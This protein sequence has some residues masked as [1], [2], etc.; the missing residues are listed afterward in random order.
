MKKKLE[1][2]Q[3]LI[4]KQFEYLENLQKKENDLIQKQVQIYE[5]KKNLEEKNKKEKREKMLQEINNYREQAIQKKQQEKLQNKLNDINFI[6][7]YKK[8]MNRLEQLE[9]EK[10]E[11]KKLKEKELYEYQKQQYELKRSQGLND[12]MKLNEDAYKKMQR[13]ENEND[14]FIKYAEGHII[15]YKNQ[16]KNIYPLLVEL[17]KYKQKY[18]I[19]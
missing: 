10:K 2:R 1:E 14:D 8:E 3:K 13:F 5:E 18:G 6:E 9:K 19:Q 16:G 17:K 12:F 11:Q 15:E 7:E 4:D